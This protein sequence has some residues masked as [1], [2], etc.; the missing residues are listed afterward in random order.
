MCGR[1]VRGRYPGCV[2]RAGACDDQRGR[3]ALEADALDQFQLVMA[4]Q[5]EHAAAFAESDVLAHRIAEQKS[6]LGYETY[7]AA[8]VL[9]RILANGP[10]IDQYCA[11]RGIVNPRNEADQGSFARAGG[12]NNRETCA[13]G[14]TQVDMAQ[15]RCSVVGEIQVAELDLPTDFCSA[16]TRAQFHR[17]AVIDL[18]LLHQNLVDASHRRGAA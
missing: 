12:A 13:R 18:R 6:F 9:E 14:N 2:A 8:Q 3:A 15:N 4:D 16:G 1:A 5:P 10:S 17:V 11:G 7:A